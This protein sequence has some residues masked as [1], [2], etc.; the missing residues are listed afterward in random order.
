MHNGNFYEK[1]IDSFD[2]VTFLH[3]SRWSITVEAGLIQNSCSSRELLH[4]LIDNHIRRLRK[5]LFCSLS[6]SLICSR[7]H[8]C[9][10]V[11][12]SKS[13]KVRLSLGRALPTST[14][15]TPWP[16]C[17]RHMFRPNVRKFRVDISSFS[18]PDWSLDHMKKWIR[19]FQ[20]AQNSWKT[21]FVK[22]LFFVQLLNAIVFFSK[23]WLFRKF[24]KR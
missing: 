7:C 8:C 1:K 10:R 13:T 4:C 6:E 2:I 16:L 21:Q 19:L 9:W 23:L 5:W 12:S 22:S 14:L 3:S 24:W 15:T 17:R 18:N 20:A 11:L